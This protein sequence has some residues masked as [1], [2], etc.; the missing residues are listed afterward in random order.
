ME[1]LKKKGSDKPLKCF[2]TLT[3]LKIF[4]HD[5]FNKKPTK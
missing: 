4:I 5:I 2:L 1:E 3:Q